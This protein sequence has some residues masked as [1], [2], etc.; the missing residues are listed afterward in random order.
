METITKRTV[1]IE[2]QGKKYTLS[3]DITIGMIL[4]QMGLPEDTHVRM[5]TTKE[6]FLIIPQ[7]E[8]N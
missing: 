6:G 7:T 5:T 2:F 3:D 8:K 1:S 4:A